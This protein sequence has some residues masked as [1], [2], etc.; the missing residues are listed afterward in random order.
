MCSKIELDFNSS[1]RQKNKSDN[2]M[3][4]IFVIPKKPIPVFME[5]IN[6]NII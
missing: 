6:N 3:W 2:F 4:F 1:R 5:L